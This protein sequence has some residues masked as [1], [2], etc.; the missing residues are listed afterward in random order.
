MQ[1]L[2]WFGR[3]ARHS[4]L[5]INHASCC[6]PFKDSIKIESW[7]NGNQIVNQFCSHCIV[8]EI[9]KKCFLFWS[10]SWRNERKYNTKPSAIQQRKKNSERKSSCCLPFK[11]S[12]K[13]YSWGSGNQIVTHLL[14]HLR[15][16]AHIALWLL[17]EMK[18]NA[19]QIPSI[20]TWY[21]QFSSLKYPVW[22]PSAIQQC[23]TNSERKSSWPPNDSKIP[24]T[25]SAKKF[26]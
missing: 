10:R 26:L 9:I 7:G 19:I 24:L 17:E 16:S 20:C 12:I 23:K 25:M 13:I 6:L 3:V 11:N 22:K 2:P 1:S 18:E 21:L 14:I 5:D 15:N 4:L 8:L